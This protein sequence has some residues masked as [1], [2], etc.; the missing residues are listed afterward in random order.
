MSKLDL[1]F[2]DQERIE[3]P[4]IYREAF[5]NELTFRTERVRDHVG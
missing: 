4:G 5:A 1:E 3:L 2:K